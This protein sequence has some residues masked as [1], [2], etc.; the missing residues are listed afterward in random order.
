MTDFDAAYA[1]E[2]IKQ[3]T[4]PDGIVCHNKN[5]YDAEVRFGSHH[6]IIAVNYRRI[7]SCY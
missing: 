5:K 2:L 4:I 3:Q 1:K 6:Y 7:E